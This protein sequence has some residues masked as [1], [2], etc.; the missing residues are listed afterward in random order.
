MSHGLF[1]LAVALLGGVRIAL[2][3]EPPVCRI[4][5]SVYPVHDPALLFLPIIT[6]CE[7]LFKGK[8]YGGCVSR[9]RRGHPPLCRLLLPAMPGKGLRRRQAATYWQFVNYP[10]TPLTNDRLSCTIIVTEGDS[11]VSHPLS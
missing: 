4:G 9:A 7:I 5:F 11:T 6:P 8:F 3:W 1:G 10:K 2:S